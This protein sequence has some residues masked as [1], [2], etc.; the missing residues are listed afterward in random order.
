MRRSGWMII[1]TGGLLAGCDAAD[2]V[3]PDTPAHFDTSPRPPGDS[4]AGAGRTDAPAEG[5]SG[6]ILIGSGT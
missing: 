3:R 6:G 2:L 4:T 5:A 1:V